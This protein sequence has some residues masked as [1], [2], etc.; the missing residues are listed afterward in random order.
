[1]TAKAAD[2]AEAVMD[3][4]MVR[5]RAWRSVMSVREKALEA[6]PEQGSEP[7]GGDGV[8]SEGEADSQPSARPGR[9]SRR[10]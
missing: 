9:N 5:F 4:L 7:A 6:G 10:S 8:P 1:M 2:G 3:E